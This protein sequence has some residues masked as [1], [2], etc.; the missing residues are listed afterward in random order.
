VAAQAVEDWPKGSGGAAAPPR[1]NG[2]YH[3]YNAAL[4]R[5]T[6]GKPRTELTPAELEAA[7]EWLGRNRCASICTCWRATT[8][9]G[10]RPGHGATGDHRSAAPQS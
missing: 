8:A 2:L 9:S 6:G 10:G 4:K 1:G 3:A 7:I 5:A